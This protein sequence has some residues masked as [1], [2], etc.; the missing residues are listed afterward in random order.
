MA[1]VPVKRRIMGLAAVG[2]LAASLLVAS[3]ISAANRGI[4]LVVDF[5]F[6]NEVTCLNPECTVG[7]NTTD[8]TV[9]SNI[10]GQWLNPPGDF[11]RPGVFHSDIYFDLRPGGTCNI[12]GE[13]ITFTFDA[14]AIFASSLHEDCNIVG[15]RINT[16]F[17]ITGGTGKFSGASGGGTE[18]APARGGFLQYDGQISY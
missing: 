5:H 1:I 14:G 11:S 16:P 8:G 15:L 10:D 12:I 6:N 3:P 4:H 18:F 13:T 7:L 17:T 9:S 2:S